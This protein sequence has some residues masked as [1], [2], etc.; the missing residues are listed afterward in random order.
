MKIFLSF[1]LLSLVFAFQPALAESSST[2]K[3]APSIFEVT[4]NP[5]EIQTQKVTLANLSA[6]PVNISSEIDNFSS[7]TTEGAPQF[8]P[9]K[10]GVANW[11]NLKESNFSLSA[12][13]EKS[14]SFTIS[15]PENTEPGGYYGAIF[16]KETPVQVNDNRQLGVVN[17]IGTIILITVS[18]PVTKS[19]EILSFT[20][21]KFPSHGPINFSVLFKNTGTVHYKTKGKIILYRGNKNIGEIN[22]AEHLVLPQ[23]LRSWQAKWPTIYRFGKFRAQLILQ[24]GNGQTLSAWLTLYFIPWQ[25][26]LLG[27]AWLAFIISVIVYIRK[28]KLKAK[29]TQV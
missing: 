10:T 7:A 9:S 3:I 25:E 6:T 5:G 12:N 24:D 17:Q 27:L 16:F 20:G 2:L 21:P 14:V 1:V 26:I 18:G 4:L 28:N 29:R 19:G 8:V 11:I 15:V 13:E 22:L 23:N